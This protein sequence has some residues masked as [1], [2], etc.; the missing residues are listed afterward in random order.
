MRVRAAT[1]HGNRETRVVSGRLNSS[2]NKQN[3]LAKI[4]FKWLRVN[5]FKTNSVVR[6]IKDQTLFC[7]VLWGGGGG[8]KRDAGSGGKEGAPDKCARLNQKPVPASCVLSGLPNKRSFLLYFGR[9][10]QHGGS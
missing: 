5:C 7:R 4:C 3:A 6:K 9:T 2:V 1:V 10:T 8:E